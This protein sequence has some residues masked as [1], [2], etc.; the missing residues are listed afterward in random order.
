MPKRHIQKRFV[1]PEEI[2]GEGAWVVVAMVTTAE[3]RKIL[4][5]YDKISEEG[6]PEQA[7][8]FGA[9]LIKRYVKEWNWVDVDGT[10]LPQISE[11]P[12][13][14]ERLIAPETQFL[15][16]CIGGTKTNLKN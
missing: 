13:V 6:T 9:Q 10:P 8:D 1:T 11:D 4:Q 12:S 7:I 3:R 14:V 15:S 2:M 16:E 5:A